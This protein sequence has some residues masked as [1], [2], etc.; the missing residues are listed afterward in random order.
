MLMAR[1]VP[2]LSVYTTKNVVPPRGNEIIAQLQETQKRLTSALGGKIQT[3]SLMMTSLEDVVLQLV[4]LVFDPLIPSAWGC[5]EIRLPE[6]A[7]PFHDETWIDTSM[8]FLKE[9]SSRK[10]ISVVAFLAIYSA[11][12]IYD[13]LLILITRVHNA[14]D[15]LEKFWRLHQFS[16]FVKQLLQEPQMIF[17]QM[18]EYVC[19]F[20]VYAYLRLLHSETGEDTY[21]KYLRHAL[22]Y[23]ISK[24]VLNLTLS[25]KE[26]MKQYY[27]AIVNGLVSSSIRY[28]D[29]IEPA[30]KPLDLLL[31]NYAEDYADCIT[32]LDPFPSDI[33]E[34]EEYREIYLQRKYGQRRADWPLQKELRS[35]LT[36]IQTSNGSCTKERLEFLRDLL[37]KKKKDMERLV[38]SLEGKQFS[39]DCTHDMLHNLIQML[40]GVI[41]SGTDEDASLEA[42]RCLGEIG[43]VD[44]S[45]LVLPICP[46]RKEIKKMVSSITTVV[47]IAAEY[48]KSNDIRVVST[49]GEVLRSLCQMGECAELLIKEMSKTRLDA[50]LKPFKTPHPIA[51]KDEKVFAN[52]LETKLGL[53]EMDEFMD[54]PVWIT[55]LTCGL[56]ESLKTD[57]S[58]TARLLP[59]CKLKVSIDVL[60]VMLD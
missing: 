21:S 42:C 51:N 43:P 40:V 18:K 5:P 49:T 29:L 56:I 53:N 7:P 37:S 36:E 39:D 55:Q 52:Q 17:N 3:E 58:L 50:I 23:L 30:K 9:S 54:Y 35:C 8:N 45:V 33:A 6:P 19:Q 34:F 4:S 27:Y 47:E 15:A 57:D 26:E 31:K 25:Y 12:S 2:G 1:I 48:L 10:D 46:S 14:H 59:L 16:Y 24:L 60:S 20:V 22:I 28:P 13:I 11:K 32:S 38:R 41:K 44:L